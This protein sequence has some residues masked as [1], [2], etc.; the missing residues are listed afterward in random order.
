MLTGVAV[1]MNLEQLHF[2]T[3]VYVM[4]QIVTTVGYGDV[5]CNSDAMKIFMSLYVLVS[6]LVVAGVLVS[7]LE[8]LQKSE[9]NFRKELKSLRTLSGVK[10][11]SSDPVKV[12]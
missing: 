11:P 7:G 5:T 1:L 6:I 4:M 9:E 3:S 10:A 12:C 2:V 8:L